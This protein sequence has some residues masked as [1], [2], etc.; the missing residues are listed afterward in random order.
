M[1]VRTLPANG[2]GQQALD[3]GCGTGHQMAMLRDLG[4]EVAG[5]DGS[6]SMLDH[7]RRNNPASELREGDVE[8]LP[9]PDASFDQVLCI[10]VLR[11]LPDPRRSIQEMA[12]VLRPGGR[13]LATATPLLNLN[14]YAIVNWLAASLRI[15]GLVVLRQYFTTS[16]WSIARLFRRASFSEVRVHGVYIGPINWIER[17]APLTLPTALKSWEPADRC[18][19]D[20]PI[21]REVSNMFLVSATR[22]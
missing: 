13:C 21:L 14:G 11:Y 2:K 20:L 12:R 19:S 10:E 7:A 9:F 17:I 8:A 16:S 18:L 3:V 15:R 6:P 5:V 22:V 1:M 4:Y